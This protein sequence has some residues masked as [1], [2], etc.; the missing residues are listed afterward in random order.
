MT[1]PTVDPAAVAVVEGWVA[2]AQR[3]DLDRLLELSTHDIDR[4]LRETIHAPDEAAFRLLVTQA[5]CQRYAHVD[6]D[7]CG[8]DVTPRPHSVDVE[9]LLL[10][11]D[12]SVIGRPGAV[13]HPG[14]YESFGVEWLGGRWLVCGASR[15]A[16]PSRS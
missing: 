14:Q 6:L 10:I 9:T 2:A 5:M 7:E 16:V 3:G 1:E 11:T 8:W 13:V 12:P 15:T 4:S